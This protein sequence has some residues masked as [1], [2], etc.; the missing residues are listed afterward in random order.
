MRYAEVGSRL[1]LIAACLESD[2]REALVDQ[3]SLS[4]PRIGHNSKRFFSNTGAW[5]SRAGGEDVIVGGKDG[6]ICHPAGS[7]EP[8]PAEL[9]SVNDYV[10]E[11]VF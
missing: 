10:N 6:V 2:G 9:V 7:C 5:N 3:P 11:T 8:C 4:L 1:L